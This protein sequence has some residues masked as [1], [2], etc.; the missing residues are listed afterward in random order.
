MQPILSAR[1]VGDYVHEVFRESDVYNWQVEEVR[2]GGISVSMKT[3]TRDI[4]P[5]GTVSGPTMF[6]LADIAAYLLTLA[7]IGKV[8]LAVTTNLSI[9]F[10]NKPEPGVLHAEGELIKLGK[11]LSVCEIR[12][13]CESPNDPE[14][15]LLVAQASATYSI[16]P[17]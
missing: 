12:I 7:H 17:R 6:A 16:P 3:G 4:R 11:R 9:N 13:F 1:E 5:G 15:R 8:A 2:P 14:K 10:L